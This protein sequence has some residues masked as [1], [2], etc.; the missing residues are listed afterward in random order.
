LDFDLIIGHGHGPS[1]TMMGI[2]ETGKPI[3]PVR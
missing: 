3:V 1:K 2:W